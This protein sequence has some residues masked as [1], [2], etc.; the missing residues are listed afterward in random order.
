[1]IPRVTTY[2]EALKVIAV[3]GPWEL[4][5]TVIRHA[6]TGRCPLVELMIIVRP[7]P[8]PVFSGSGFCSTDSACMSLGWPA[9]VCRSVVRAADRAWPTMLKAL[10]LAKQ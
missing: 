8:S 5:R 7:I 10:G 3:Y 4:R 1:M 2:A 9:H 6:N